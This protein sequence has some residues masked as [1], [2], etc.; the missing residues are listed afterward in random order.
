MQRHHRKVRTHFKTLSAAKCTFRLR[1]RRIS[2]KVLNV[3][4]ATPPRFLLI[5]LVSLENSIFRFRECF[6]MS[7]GPALLIGSVC[8]LI[9][10]LSA[11]PAAAK[12]VDRI[13]AVVNGDIVTQSDLNAKTAARS[14]PAGR[15][16]L[17][18]AAMQASQNNDA[19]LERLIDELLL[20]QAVDKAKVEVTD[21]DIGRAMQNILAQN[22]MTTEQLREEVA[23]KGMSFD[24][25]KEQ[26][27]LEIKKIKFVNQVISTDIKIT[28]RDLRDYYER[29]KTSI[30]GGKEV[31]IAEIVIPFP[32]IS[33]QDE[34]NAFR[35]AAYDIAKQAQSG[36]TAFETLAKQHSKGPN[37]DKGGD[38]G[39][40]ALA[41]LPQAVAAAIK[42]MPAGMVTNPTPTDTAVIIAKIIEW[43][44]LAN[45]NFDTV[46]DTIYQKMYDERLKEALD[47]YLQKMRQTA[48]IELR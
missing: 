42:G 39:V 6:K 17:P 3:A 13:V 9:A 31:H 36:K 21:D 40:V 15:H 5:L 27:K 18:S 37:A 48:Y 43:P 30:G 25:Y 41:D 35:D 29:N 23:R 10:T 47:G 1:L 14:A 34:A 11:A 7:S 26:L 4:L 28:D 38:L 19:A 22:S 46:R 2:Q 12:V 45:D 32:S 8:A 24:Q 16:A 33:S 44:A 20:K